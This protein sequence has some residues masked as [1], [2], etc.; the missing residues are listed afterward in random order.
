M[1]LD[2]S[3]RESGDITIIDLRGRATIGDGESDLLR[4][5]LD[6]LLARG[7]RKLVL[8]LAGMTHVDSSGFSVIVR[9]CVSARDKGGDMRFV[10][11]TGS[12]LL[13]FNVLRLVDMIRTFDNE[14]EAVASFLSSNSSAQS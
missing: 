4:A 5:R 11:P 2:I 14:T 6:Q 3:I 9:I 7:A 12:A 13:S 10:R 1:A 8:N